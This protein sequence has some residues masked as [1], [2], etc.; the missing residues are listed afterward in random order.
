MK[1][2]VFSTIIILGILAIFLFPTELTM[3]Q[4]TLSML[5][6]A[7]ILAFIIFAAF[8]LKEKPLDEREALHTWKAGRLSFLVGTSVLILA[9]I[10]QAAKHNID[11]WL[12]IALAAMVLSKILWR[13]YSHKKL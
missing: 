2:E 9:V 13:I 12:V 5:I 8:I 10:F 6:V 11:P 1:I 3:P 7:L 4:T